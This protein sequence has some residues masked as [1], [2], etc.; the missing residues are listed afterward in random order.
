MFPMPFSEEHIPVK[1]HRVEHAEIY[2]LFGE[3]LRRIEDE[4]SRVGTHLQFATAW[5][6]VA[7][8]LTVTL[9]TIPI[10]K[11]RV[12]EAILIFTIVSYGFALFHGVCAWQQ[13]GRFKSII[14]EI[15]QRKAG[16]LGEKGEE[17][18]PSELEGLPSQEAA[19]AEG[20]Q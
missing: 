8:A 3:D 15:R 20:K 5:F 17:L 10:P 14:A 13:R 2:E 11:D 6:P 16:P 12:F 19:P 1:R 4:G 18:K 9:S 7:I